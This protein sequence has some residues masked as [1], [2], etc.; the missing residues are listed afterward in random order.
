MR[1]IFVDL[2][3]IK[4]SKMG[5]KTIIFIILGSFIIVIFAYFIFSSTNK[6]SPYPQSY[7]EQDELRPQVKVESMLYDLGSMKVSEKKS[8]DFIIKNVGKKPLQLSSIST[9]CMCTFAQIIYEG[10]ESPEFDMHSESNYIAEIQSDKR[11]ILR[12]TYKPYLMPV[13]GFIER[14]AHVRTNDPAMQEL[15]FKVTANVK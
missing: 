7:S 8:Y 6:V 5:K 15:V 13:Y 2:A 9:S 11:A 4:N 12:M 1:F 14:E 3:V 10:K